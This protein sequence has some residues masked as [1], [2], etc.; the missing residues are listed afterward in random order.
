MD[1]Q[2]LEDYSIVKNK[3]EYIK[4]YSDGSVDKN[5]NTPNIIFEVINVKDKDKNK[6]EDINKH[7]IL[8]KKIKKCFDIPVN[9]ALDSETLL[10]NIKNGNIQ[11]RDDKTAA[12]F[13]LSSRI[14]HF[15]KSGMN[16]DELYFILQHHDKYKN[17]QYAQIKDPQTNKYRIPIT[18]AELNSIENLNREKRNF[19]IVPV[20][21]ET[22]NYAHWGAIVIHFDENNNKEY[23]VFDAQQRKNE[24]VFITADDGLEQT[25]ELLNIKNI[26]GNSNLCWLYTLEFMKEANTYTNFK[27]LQ[28][29]CSEKQNYKLQKQVYENVKNTLSEE[30][31]QL[32]TIVDKRATSRIV[33]GHAGGK[34][35]TDIIKDIKENKQISDTQEQNVNGCITKSQ[36]IV[37]KAFPELFNAKTKKQNIARDKQA[38]NQ[39]KDSNVV[40][41]NKQTSTLHL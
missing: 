6:N 35:E 34:S 2:Y 31:I 8:F 22:S 10:A 7:I 20:M 15:T 30:E 39:F 5:T 24:G 17:I 27:D 40:P 4:Q 12:S 25:P 32:D 1:F 9:T 29:A 26:Q 38:V 16:K 19:E 11:P 21:K 3:Q 13:I 14:K 36:K 37:F 41:Q 18:N 33:G 23:Y 28:R